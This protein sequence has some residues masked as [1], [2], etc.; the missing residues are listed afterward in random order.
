MVLVDDLTILVLQVLLLDILQVLAEA[1]RLGLVSEV[2]VDLMHHVELLMQ[3]V[4]Q[5][6]VV[7]LHTKDEPVQLHVEVVIMLLTIPK[8]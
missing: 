3:P 5:L 4:P 6:I 1:H 2:E 7:I 8:Q